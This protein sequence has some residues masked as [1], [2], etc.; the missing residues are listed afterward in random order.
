MY[1]YG[2]E[3]LKAIK[4]PTRW[5]T[6][7]KPCV[8]NVALTI[9]IV[10]MMG[11]VL[12]PAQAASVPGGYVFTSVATATYIPHG[13]TQI[14]TISSNTV[15]AAVQ[16]V[17]ALTLTQS[18][19]VTRPP[20][21]TMT[22]SHVLVNVGNV[23]SNYTLGLVVNGAGCGLLSTEALLSVKLVR[24]INNSGV[25][26]AASPALLLGTPGAL[27][28]QP[29]EI[30]V[31]LV[32]ANLPAE[33]KGAA[34]LTLSVTTAQGLSAVN[35]DTVILASN[36]VLTLT[37]SASH[38]NQ[39]LSSISDINFTVSGMNIGAR[40]ALPTGSGPAP[41]TLP[42]TVNGVPTALVLIQD[43]IPIGTKYNANSLDTS[44]VGALKLYRVLGDAPFTYRQGDGGT[45]AIEVAIGIPSPLVRDGLMT[46]SFSVRI[47]ALHVGNILNNAQGYFYDGVNVVQSASNT[48]V[49]AST[50]AVIGLA[51]AAGVTRANAN[52]TADVTFTLR[53][54][55][56]GSLPLYNVQ[57]VDLMEGTGATQFGNYT[58]QDV[59]GANQYTVLG[60]SMA[61][62]QN[63]NN[64]V[65]GPVAAVNTQ[66]TG[67]ATFSQLLGAG[68]VLPVGAEMSMV[69]DVRFNPNGRGATLLNT[70]TASAALTTDA[71]VSVFDVSTDGTNPDP[72]GYGKPGSASVPTP[73]AS[74]APLLSLTQTA[75]L[76]RRIALG[77][78]E[79]D[80]TFKVSNN[81]TVNAPN[82][83]IYDNLNCTFEMD[84]PAGRVASWEM[85]GAI[86]TANGVLMA[87]TTFNSATSCD[88]TGLTAQTPPMAVNLSLVDGSRGL[89]AGQ[90]ETIKLTVRVTEKA[91]F[92]RERSVFSNKAWAVSLQ[93]N[94]IN[95][96]NQV[97]AEASSVVLAL[98][99][100]PQG[101]V[102]NALTRQ[103]VAGAIVT[104]A[105]TACLSST[106]GPIVPA[107]I[108]GADVA[109]LYTFNANGSLSM[110]TGNDG[111]YQF[112]LNAPPVTDVCT[113][114]LTVS[115]PAGSAYRWPSLLV[116][117]HSG[118]FASCGAVAAQALAPTGSDLTTYYL[119]VNA[120]VVPG[121]SQFCD[122]LYNHI[123]L[124][125]GSLSGLTLQKE[126][127]K[128]QAEFGD[129]IDYALTI[130]NKTGVLVTGLTV[131]DQLPP[132]LAYVTGSA[133]LNVQGGLEPGMRP[134][135]T[136]LFNYP[137]LVLEVNGTAIVRYRVRIG[138]GAPTQ[139]EVIN[140]A[141]ANSG[142][143]QSNSASFK[144]RISAGVFS[145]DA[146]AFGKVYM[147]CARVATRDSAS[148][149]TEEVGIAGVRLYLE[150]G[151]NVITD[152]EGKWSL[153]GLKPVTHVLRLDQTTLPAGAIL[154][155]L[156][157]RNS[158]TPE[159]RFMD[160]KKGEFHKADFVVTN[161]DDALVRAEVS[162][163]RLA[164]LSRADSESEAR[165]RLRLDP[166]NRPVV[167]S[168]VR[169]LPASSLGASGNAV[170]MAS[171]SVTG[172]LIELPTAVGGG[173]ALTPV[174]Q[175]GQMGQASSLSGI[176][177]PALLPEPVAMPVKPAVES[178]QIT[179][180]APLAEAVPRPVV[181]VVDLKVL[182]PQL[183]NQWAFLGL[184]DGDTMTGPVINVR[185]KGE[186][187]HSLRLSV[188]G[189]V[190]DEHRVGTKATLES[191]N[192][193]AWEYIGI[194]LQAGVN[195][196]R[197]DAVDSFGINRFS[198]TISVTV[199][200]Q[201]AL[202]QIDLPALA[203]ADLRTPVVI[204]VRLSDA[205][206][207][208]VTAR[209][210]LTLEADRGRWLD[211]DRDPSEP[212]TQVFM[213]GGRAQFQLQAPAEPGE[214]RLRVSAG[215]L[216]KEVRLVLLPEIRPM[217]GVGVVEGV[218]D[219]TKRGAL[220]LGAMP[221]GAAFESELSSLG[222]D[223][224]GGRASAR[225]AFF[226]KGTVQGDYL[227]TAAFDS[228]KAQHDRLFRD[229]RPDEFYPV[230]GDAS[231]RG[232]EAQS[233]QKLY[234]RID[235]NRSYL[236]YGDFT[237]ASSAEVRQLSQ[238]NRTLTGVKTVYEDTVLR[239]TSYASRTAQ[240]QQVEEFASVGTSGPYFLS[241]GGGAE[242]VVN[243]EVV[244]I[245]V[246]DRVQPGVVLSST[247]VTRFV[248][249]TLEPYTRRLL[250][251][252][253]IAS[254]DTRLNPQS[255]R[256]TYEVNSGGAEFL[257]AGTD[258][259]VKVADALQ[260]GVVGSMDENPVNH[261]KLTAVTALSRLGA[262]T[263]L[264]SEVV[265]TETDLKGTGYA[266]RVDLRQQT[267]R[268]AIAV[269]GIRTSEG[270][271]NP[272]ASSSAGR[273]DA[274][275]RVE[276]VLSAETSLRAEAVY[277]KTL[278][279]A[280]QNR[281]AAS[282]QQKF[283]ATTVGELGLNRGQSTGSSS[284][285]DYGQ[286]A[287]YNGVTGG[288]AGG[289]GLGGSVGAAVVAST[290]A[291]LASSTA[292]SVTTVRGRVTTEVPG[293]PQAKVFIEGEQ[294]VAQSQR[295]IVAV[296]GSYALTDK[297]RAYGRYELLSTL[298]D[299][300]VA[301]GSAQPHNTAILGVDSNYME[302]G[303]VYNEYRLAQAGDVRP[304]QAAMGVRNAI[305]LS[306]EIQFTGGIEQTKS[307]G[308]AATGSTGTG[309]GLAMGT[310]NS[311]AVISGVDYMT[312]RFKAS[313]VAEM[314]RGSDATTA[315]VSAGMGYKLDADWRLLTRSVFTDSQ[316]QGV[317]AGNERRLLRNQV[318]VALRPA[319]Q[320]VWNALARYEHKLERVGINSGAALPTSVTAL[321]GSNAPG[322]YST[323][324]ISTHLNV[325]PTR[326][327]YVTV[328]YAGKIA[329]AS[330]A[331]LA[332]RYWA[333][334]VQGRYTHDIAPDWDL[335]VQG[336]V[337]LGQ[338]HALQKTLGLEA[339]YQ[340]ARNTW[341]SVGFNVVGLTDRDLAE[342]DYTSKGVYIRL[343]FKF[344]ERTLGLGGAAPGRAV[345][346]PKVSP[347]MTNVAALQSPS[348]APASAWPLVW[349]PG[350][351]VP[352]Q[353]ALRASTLFEPAQASVS[354]AGAVLLGQLGVQL[355]AQSIG[356]IQILIQDPEPARES[357]HDLWLAR[358]GALRSALLDD[359]PRMVSISLGSQPLAPQA[360]PVQ[361]GAARSLVVNLVA[362]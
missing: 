145:D 90:F 227:L 215:R 12:N 262:S 233:S 88:R 335:G 76:P 277:G 293:L 326:G 203:R 108:M 270:F 246:R 298:V 160:L 147:S 359:G 48:T 193:A 34:C 133:R 115:P 122:V 162:A 73:V 189:E 317:N 265:K 50:Q 37:N 9:G 114:S 320:D 26:D 3:L 287:A 110:T 275:A 198:Q 229:I 86:Q 111:A 89:L 253:A 343:R 139:G 6:F 174:R 167:V 65:G 254:V 55:N 94:S 271:D 38:P 60:G 120:G 285:F 248:D 313:G 225:S 171:P 136:L 312:E 105:R 351:V 242:L 206:G 288:S 327:E 25:V 314:R 27:V 163:R 70:A 299:P 166:E 234:V 45:E 194:Q 341:I 274:S 276:Y 331:T 323:D 232:F 294:D 306:K 176:F 66:F 82:V 184:T 278:N 164:Q 344:D 302:G 58:A 243:S 196:L 44:V 67:Q 308:G 153:Y 251:T 282:V 207:V 279:G 181:V 121:T 361:L 42:L 61:V 354:P 64:S 311:T 102:Y 87:A 296:G 144:T 221:A 209:T 117:P 342:A 158:G 329:R 132:G 15:Y 301:L 269:Q 186:M 130:T 264:A 157:N 268:L 168:D 338:H 224:M 97:R 212:G 230:Y 165:V 125:S 51:K 178:A 226:F 202:I 150:N 112:Y 247:P 175:I 237:T 239:A 300:S 357:I 20:S 32:Q 124:D 267:E 316:G 172:A 222:S 191:E 353:I 81:G 332:S 52:G 128:T 18:Q 346:A 106:F 244:T 92:A 217:I 17:E 281:L 321:G 190:I 57:V 69:F 53:I 315:L 324:I 223:P 261:R 40:D 291:S 358:A 149:A 21:S 33:A 28:L 208:P 219:F 188:N 155:V 220:T 35:N 113:Y 84:L 307:M 131:S 23:S 238:S 318:G 292:A 200:G 204:G 83:R 355:N 187:N 96:A 142:V 250:F 280:E 31:L 218:L 257:V 205:H 137:S 126:G 199:P 255:I 127:S 211:A 258:V 152:D 8:A 249:Y 118:V 156:D 309:T 134:G 348:L 283:S 213:E 159:S 29:G 304:V 43:V 91:N 235:K 197:L 290:A 192:L 101:I 297:T 195:T 295:H 273:T 107:E 330:D 123:A 109:G 71:G 39:V 356:P 185:V 201:L 2:A 266:S 284:G 13:Y 85:V 54:K 78:Y 177:A 104:V 161:C 11:G 345:E 289:S 252:H 5:L 7:V 63:L 30:A 328:R 119:Q 310:G 236:L 305:K 360:D 1:F 214:A 129:F 19:S 143:L 322:S 98:L 68:A 16:A 141:V 46:M 183:N 80:Y 362:N 169:A 56:Y 77:V 36:A 146:Y 103:P 95:Q 259:Q 41:A 347:E 4:Q 10:V 116:P 349:K 140:R 350:S 231:I 210:A 179:L 14:E 334:L 99:I 245:V 47:N 75:S 340:V 93:N 135:A 256:V 180:D 173:T 241:A 49:V 228:D 336:G 240:T 59:P 337:L 260:L 182:L 325:N 352:A 24:D 74:L 333:H 216:S 319:E 286:T 272:G 148:N 62:L 22:L 170:S 79:L 72:D 303:R 339:G 154:G 138:V 263:T 100:D 151:T